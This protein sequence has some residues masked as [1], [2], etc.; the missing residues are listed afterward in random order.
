MKNDFSYIVWMNVTKEKWGAH[1]RYAFA[2]LIHIH[3][4]IHIPYNTYSHYMPV[5]RCNIVSHTEVCSLLHDTGF[6]KQHFIHNIDNEQPHTP[7][8]IYVNKYTCAHFWTWLKLLIHNSIYMQ[9]TYTCVNSW[10]WHGTRDTNYHIHKPIHVWTYEHD[11]ELMIQISVHIAITNKT[12]ICA[13]SFTP[14][15]VFSISII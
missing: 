1:E 6:I 8:F 11:S 5:R 14:R 3:I 10:T 13:S 12:N 9:H 7:S 2:F 15:F 4:Q